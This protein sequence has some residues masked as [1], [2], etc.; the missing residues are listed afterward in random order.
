[1]APATYQGPAPLPPV[2]ASAPPVVQYSDP[3][4]SFWTGAATF[5]GGAAIGGL[6]GYVIGDDDDDDN[7]STSVP[8]VPMRSTTAPWISGTC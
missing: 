6:L 8:L 1:M 2:Y 5:A 3:S 7:D 4:P